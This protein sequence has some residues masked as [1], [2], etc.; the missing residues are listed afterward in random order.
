MKVRKELAISA[1][2]QAALTAKLL[3]PP[4]CGGKSKA[5]LE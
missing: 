1:A 3:N 5:G 4:R 2:R